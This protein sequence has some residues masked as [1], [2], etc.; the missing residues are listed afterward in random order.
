MSMHLD[1]PLK[2]T[3]RSVKYKCLRSCGGGVDVGG[4]SPRHSSNGKPPPIAF[5]RFFAETRIVYNE[6]KRP[7]KDSKV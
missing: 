2:L 5:S 3:E 1:V 6:R 7:L 4:E